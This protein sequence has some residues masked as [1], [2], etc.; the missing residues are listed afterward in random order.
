[1]VTIGKD[2]FPPVF[3]FFIKLQDQQV[4]SGVLTVECLKLIRYHPDDL[5]KTSPKEYLIV[6]FT[7][8]KDGEC[9]K[10]IKTMS[11]EQ[12]VKSFILSIKTAKNEKRIG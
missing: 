6:A 5:K 1:M 2:L 12:F 8:I 9:Q 4:E 11:I 10:P 3:D 7:P